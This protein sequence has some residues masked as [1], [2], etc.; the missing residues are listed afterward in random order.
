MQSCP[1]GQ[2]VHIEPPRPQAK[3]VPIEGVTHRP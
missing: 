2:L 3:L 1:R